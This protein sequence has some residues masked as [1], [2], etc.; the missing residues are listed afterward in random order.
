MTEQ[1]EI[2]IVTLDQNPEL[3]QKIDRVRNA[4]IELA[5]AQDEL[6]SPC[7][8]LAETGGAYIAV[9][10]A[11]QANRKELRDSNITEDLL[12]VPRAIFDANLRLTHSFYENIIHAAMVEASKQGLPIP[13]VE[14][15]ESAE[16]YRAGL[17]EQFFDG[18]KSID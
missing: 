6:W 15:A 14:V 9:R 16:T 12:V 3:S 18:S 8:S 2:E 11:A 13:S 10:N 17:I 4:I 7:L 1:V 5:V